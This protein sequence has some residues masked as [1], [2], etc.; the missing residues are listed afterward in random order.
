MSA[1]TRRQFALAAAD[2]ASAP[3]ITAS[4]QPRASW[5]LHA[6]IREKMEVSDGIKDELTRMYPFPLRRMPQLTGSRV[7]Q[8]YMDYAIPC[9]VT[10]NGMDIS[11][12]CRE[13][14]ET[15]GWAVVLAKQ[16]K[17]ELLWGDVRIE[18]IKKAG[19]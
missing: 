11:M 1:L 12:L 4:G 8:L 14:D 3:T 5:W 7:E 18:L 6:G 10:H 13:A 19:R 16:G 15:H 9:C 17:E 2:I